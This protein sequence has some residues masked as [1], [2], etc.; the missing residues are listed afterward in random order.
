MA[1][2]DYYKPLTLQHA[3]QAVDAYGDSVTEY[4]APVAVL[5]Y[6]GKPSSKQA[7]TLGQR[8]IDVDGRLYAPVSA[9]VKAFDAITDGA[10]RVWEVVSEPRDAADR[11]HHV[12][13]DLRRVRGGAPNAGRA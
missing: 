7:V 3:A 11:G 1:I 13:A 4:G 8:G 9:G 5:G 10:G 2:E 6:I 12:E